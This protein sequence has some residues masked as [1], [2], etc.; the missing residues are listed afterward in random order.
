MKGHIIEVGDGFAWELRSPNGRGMGCSGTSD[1]VGSYKDEQAAIEAFDKV[2]QGLYTLV[3][4]DGSEVKATK[5][6]AAAGKA[7]SSKVTASGSGAFD[8]LPQDPEHP[9]YSPYAVDGNKV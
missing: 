1:E 5:A 8:S 9:L 2:F 7:A 6:K 3:K 4:L